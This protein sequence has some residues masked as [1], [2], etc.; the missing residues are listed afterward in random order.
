[1]WWLKGRVTRIR[2]PLNNV[3]HLSLWSPLNSPM[4]IEHQMFNGWMEQWYQTEDRIIFI[5]NYSK[6]YHH[7][8][9]CVRE[10]W[11]W[12]VA[13]SEIMLVFHLIQSVFYRLAISSGGICGVKVNWLEREENFI[14]CYSTKIIHRKIEIDIQQRD[15]TVLSHLETFNLIQFSTV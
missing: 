12:R 5:K 9:V 15:F 8:D 1:M 3:L 4:Y 10:K 14:T 2:S 7:S 13:Q 11:W 6:G